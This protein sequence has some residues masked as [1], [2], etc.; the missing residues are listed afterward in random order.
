MLTINV[1]SGNA[2]TALIKPNTVA[3]SET[4][5]KKYFR[6]ANPVGETITIDHRP[7]QVTAVF[8]NVPLHFHLKVNYLLS[9]ASTDWNKTHETNWQ[10]QQIY[11]YI[12]LKHGADAQQLESKFLPFVE[13]YAYPTIQP[14]GFT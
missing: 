4:L 13:K 2:A 7:Y 12:K 9:F 10:R 6:Q 11:T 1:I 3:I 8:A 14:K 5:A